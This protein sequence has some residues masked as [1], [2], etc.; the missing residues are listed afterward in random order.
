MKLDADPRWRR[1]NDQSYQCPC[2][3]RSFSGI[4]DIAYDHPDPWRHGTFRDNAGASVQ[5]GADWLGSDLC[6]IGDDH[7][8]RG[9]IA[10]PVQGSPTSFAFGAWASLH[11]DRF[12]AYV[13]AF[14]SGAESALD[15]CFGWLSNELPV[16]GTGTFLK[17]EVRFQGGTA[18]PDFMVWDASSAL[19]RDQVTG[20]TFDQLLDL[21]AASGNDIRHHLLNG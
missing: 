4:F 11:K 5:V 18:R 2:C 1:F 17:T 7:F 8:V 21:Y 19:A 10:I 9:T 6:M 12:Q 20:I 16:Y 13:D 3:N 15:P 14:G